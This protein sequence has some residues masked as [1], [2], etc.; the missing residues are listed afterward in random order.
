MSGTASSKSMGL[1]SCIE[2][3]FNPSNPHPE[4]G[5]LS[6]RLHILWVSATIDWPSVLENPLHDESFGM[7][8]WE[9]YWFRGMRLK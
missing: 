6:F 9:M 8:P 5:F 4:T 2:G 7:V 3:T 1:K